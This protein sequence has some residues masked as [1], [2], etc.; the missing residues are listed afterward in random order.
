ME[1]QLA[2]KAETSTL[3]TLY[4]SKSNP[5]VSGTL[6]I[7]TNTISFTDPNGIT[8]NID[9]YMLQSL[10]TNYTIWKTSYPTIDLTPYVTNTSLT[11]TLGSYAK[12]TDLNAYVSNTSLT[13]TLTTYAKST[14]L[15]A[16]VSNTSLT[17]TL[18]AYAKSTDLNAYVTSV[19]LT[20]TL[21]S[22]AK[23][24]DLSPY[25]LKAGATFTGDIILSAANMYQG[26][27][28]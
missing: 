1:T 18:S 19:S 10:C 4:V 25:A 26:P 20:T 15:N 3:P 5:T 24:T 23:T 21:G 27:T 16:Y 22:Y 12:S 6:N 14:D 7:G 9:K 2:T 8:Q 13:T 28:A 11:T 17:T